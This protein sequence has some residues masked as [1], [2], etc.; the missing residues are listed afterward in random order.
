LVAFSAQERRNRLIFWMVNVGVAG[1]AVGL[2]AENALLK[3]IFTP[4]MGLGLLLAIYTYLT[5]PAA[6]VMT[7]SSS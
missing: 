5:A 1:F 6:E 3:R 4:V 7:S 2:I